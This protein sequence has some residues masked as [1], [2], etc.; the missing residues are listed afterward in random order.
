MSIESFMQ[1]YK[2]AWEGRDEHAF[3]AL[4]TPGGRYHNTPFAVQEG[5]AQLAQYWQR[6][7]LQNDIHV[8]YQVLATGIDSGI[9]HW[10]VNY[11]VASEELFK[12]WAASTAT[13]LL[14]RK[15]G[16]PLPRLTLDGILR[17][18]FD[19]DGRCRECWLWWHSQA[20]A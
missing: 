2:A 11:Q 14:D 20:Q 3:C 17:A 8:S 7:K 15:P 12:I 16:D 1:A 18:E 10:H 5:Y 19:A 13:H 4:F 9:A 6:V